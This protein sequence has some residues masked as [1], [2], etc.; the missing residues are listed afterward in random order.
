MTEEP[1]PTSDTTGTLHQQ[2]SDRETSRDKEREDKDEECLTESYSSDED[3]IVE[4]YSSEEEI[5]VQKNETE[6]TSTGASSPS[7][8]ELLKVVYYTSENVVSQQNCQLCSYSFL[9]PKRNTYKE[10]GE[11]NLSTGNSQGNHYQPLPTFK[12]F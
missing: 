11:T 12:L 3:V 1:P 2:L 6:V 9:G 4:G 8:I 7:E 10:V 5:G